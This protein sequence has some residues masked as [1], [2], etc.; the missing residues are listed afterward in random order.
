MPPLPETSL[1]TVACPPEDFSASLIARA[2]EDSD[3]HL[4]N[5]NVTS[6]RLEG[7]LLAVELRTNHSCPDS[8]VRSLRRYGFEV[9][10]ARSADV[11]A[12]VASDDEALRDRAAELLH[13]L[14]V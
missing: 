2:V 10:D 7:G 8:A 13:I 12:P 5:M 4:I 9:I 14:N 11:S 3:A 6:R 1:I